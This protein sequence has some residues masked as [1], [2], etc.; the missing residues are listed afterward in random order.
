MEGKGGAVAN[1]SQ[2]LGD[3]SKIPHSATDNLCDPRQVMQA[4]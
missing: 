4:H 1:V 3:F 2:D